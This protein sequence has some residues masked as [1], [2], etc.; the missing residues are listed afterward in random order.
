MMAPTHMAAGAAAGLNIAHMAGFSP[1]LGMVLG[2]VGSLLPDLDHPNGTIR[3]R[4]SGSKLLLFWLSHRGITHS[5][6]FLFILIAITQA[7]LP[8]PSGISRA[9][10]EGFAS[11]LLLDLLTKRGIPMF[12]P[13]SWENISLLPIRTGGMIETLVIMPSLLLLILYMLLGGR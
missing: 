11:H 8:L 10:T 7:F 4:L 2:A 9:I 13:F 12:A 5:L 3:N 6:V 1:L